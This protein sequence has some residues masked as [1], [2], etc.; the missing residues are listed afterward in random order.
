MTHSPIN[1]SWSIELHCANDN[2]QNNNVHV[3]NNNNNNN[4]M[5]H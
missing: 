1:V 2:G 3:T 4:T 5:H